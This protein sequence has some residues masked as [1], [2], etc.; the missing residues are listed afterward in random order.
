MREDDGACDRRADRDSL[1]TTEKNNKITSLPFDRNQLN[2]RLCAAKQLTVPSRNYL[3]AIFCG[4]RASPRSSSA[5]ACF[6]IAIEPE[7]K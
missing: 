4:S 2:V 6:V 5:R 1:S 3:V 7:F